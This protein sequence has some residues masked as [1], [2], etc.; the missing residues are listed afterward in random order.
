VCVA[1]ALVTLLPAAHAAAAPLVPTA[2]PAVPGNE[3][4]PNNSPATAS[5]IHSGER[6]RANLLASGDVDYYR[7]EAR[8]GERVFANTVTAGSAGSSNDSELTLL[9]GDGTAELEFDDNDGSQLASASSIAGAKIPTD[10]T[11]YLKVK[12]VQNTPVTEVPYDL[13]LQLRSGTPP[14]ESEPNDEPGQA[15]L[16]TTGEVTGTHT[17]NDRDWY[18]MELHEGDT[19]FLSLDLEPNRDGETFNGRLG[20]GRFGDASN[21]VLVVDDPSEGEPPDSTPPSEALTMT[22]EKTGIYYAYVDSGNSAAGTG[23]DLSATVIPASQPSCRS[24]PSSLSGDFFDG[25]S[26]TYPISVGDPARIARAA[27]RLN[28]EDTLMADVDVSLRNPA[29]V[30]LPLFTDIGAVAPGGQKHL[31]AV[32]DEYAAVQPLYN[33]LR[34]LDLQPERASRLGWLEGEQAQ[35]EW[36]VV[37]RDDELNS[38][39][40][41]VLGAELILCPEAEPEELP[42]YF[43]GFESGEEGFATGGVND[44]WER[45]TP[46]TP[47]T[48]TSNPVAGLSACAEGVACFKTNLNGPYS[49]TSSQ[50]LVSPAISLAGRSGPIIASWDQWYQMDSVRS[51]RASVVVEEDGGGHPRTLWEWTGPQMTAEL[52]NPATNNQYPVAAGWGLHRVD[53]SEYAGK[54][55][56]LRF[57]LASDGNGVNLAG[58]AIDDVR[59]SERLSPPLGSSSSGTAASNG[60]GQPNAAL[61]AAPVLSGLAIAPRKFRAAKAGATVLAKRPASGGALVSYQ[62]SQAAQTNV[63]L[64]KAEP[65]RKVGSKCARQTKANATRKP[66]T[67]YVKLT[68]FVRQD[69]AGSNQ[70]ALSGRFNA[71]SLP[72]GEYQLQAKAFATSGLTSNPV[73]VNFTILAAVPS[74]K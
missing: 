12:D 43:A 71:K 13:Y 56:R 37:V 70:F 19:V 68:S 66:C 55:I 54:T 34:P 62:D 69:A 73:G 10:G 46:N 23:Y 58:L 49:G 7:F 51:D 35:G 2:L 64:L 14:S 22:V 36:A 41:K 24:Y 45:G 3:V 44:Q 5:P 72:P 74:S 11:Y 15:T 57:H 42:I 25:G 61:A 40:G 60:G 20:L 33:S 52:G 48:N 50:D 32:F 16:L 6:I 67:R 9:A 63:V 59:V 29:G 47:A 39:S 4:E 8:A 27:V 26:L 18:S 30:E 17:A 53:I 31:E 38:S 1:F 21:Q 65:G 28:L